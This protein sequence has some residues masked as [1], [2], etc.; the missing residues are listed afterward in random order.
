MHDKYEMLDAVIIAIDK[1]E[2]A[3]GVEKCRI[4]L[5]AI[6]RIG[7]LKEGLKKEDAVH[8]E[9]IN[10]LSKPIK[11]L[12]SP[13]QVKDG[14]VIVGGEEYHIGVDGTVTQINEE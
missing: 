11:E 9:H 7:V 13:P 10:M 6:Q 14:E 3:R 12:T 5:D 1:L 4:I 2:D 8:A